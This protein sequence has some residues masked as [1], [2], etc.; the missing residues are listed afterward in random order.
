MV[1]AAI[2]PSRAA[3]LALPDLSSVAAFPLDRALVGCP[4]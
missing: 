3:E 1:A 4:A 2:A